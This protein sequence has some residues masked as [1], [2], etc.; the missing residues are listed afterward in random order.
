MFQQRVGVGHG[1]LHLGPALALLPDSLQTLLLGAKLAA[2]PPVQGLVVGDD[3]LLAEE[4]RGQIQPVAPKQLLQPLIDRQVIDRVVVFF[5]EVAAGDVQVVTGA[6]RHAAGKLPQLIPVKLGS[7]KS[8]REGVVDHSDKQRGGVLERGKQGPLDALVVG[9][10]IEPQAGLD[11]D[12]ALEL[13]AVSGHRI[14]RQQAPE[15]ADYSHVANFITAFRKLFGC[16]PRQL[17]RHGRAHTE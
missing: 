16:S 1:D 11:G 7:T 13:A 6:R 3:S 14:Q 12:L 10:I 8:R 5:L 17:T 4:A 2:K 15:H 9:R